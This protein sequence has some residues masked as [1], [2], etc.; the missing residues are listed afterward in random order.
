M[1]YVKHI[2]DDDLIAGFEKTFVGLHF[3]IFHCHNV[4]EIYILEEGERNLIIDDLMYKTRDYDAAMIKAYSCHRSYGD[5]PY[6]GLCINFSDKYLDKYYSKTAKEYLLSCFSQPIIH[7]T[8]EY[9]NK[10]HRLTELITKNTEDKFIYLADILNI[11]ILLAKKHDES[12]NLLQI[13]VLDPII[14]YISDNFTQIQSLDDISKALHIN[15]NYLCAL[16]KRKTGMTVSSYIN[17]LRIH[18]A[19]TLLVNTNLSVDDI[20]FQCGFHSTS[21]FC[22]TFKK[23]LDQTPSEFR[24]SSKANI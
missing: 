3:P 22:R 7:L 4:Y 2:Y 15:K 12:Y 10:I 6:S 11:L 23:F 20:G 17:M 18:L 8:E 1:N 19:S 14:K 21:Y 5:T 16:F 24:Q 9:Y 13:P